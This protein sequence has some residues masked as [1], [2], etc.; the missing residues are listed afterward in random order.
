M[1]GGS[2][3]NGMISLGR[4]GVPAAFVSEVGYDRIGQRTVAFLKENGVTRRT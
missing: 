4:A 1:P 3:Y 2:V